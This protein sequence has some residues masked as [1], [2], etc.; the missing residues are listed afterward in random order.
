M[1]NPNQKT[2][3]NA[4][5]PYYV[6][7]ACID[8]DMCRAHAP[9][10]FHRNDDDAGLTYVARQPTTPDEHTLAQEALA[11]CPVECIGNDG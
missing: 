7:E 8:C 5:G 4:P 3:N 1:A 6:D 11:D 2:S 10:I 9:A